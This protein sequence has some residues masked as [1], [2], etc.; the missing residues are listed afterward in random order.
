MAFKML[1]KLKMANLVKKR[2]GLPSAPA[3]PSGAASLMRKPSL[4]PQR[5]ASQSAP[6]NPPG[7]S[8]GNPADPSAQLAAAAAA[9]APLAEAAAAQAQAQAPAPES[10]ANAAGPTERG[11]ASRPS[12]PAPAA[13]ASAAPALPPP[14]PG[15]SS[16]VLPGGLNDAF[17]LIYRIIAI[18]ISLVIIVYFLTAAL[19]MFIYRRTEVQQKIRKTLNKNIMNKD[20]TDIA[21]IDYLKNNSEDE[22]YNVFAEQKMTSALYMLSGIGVIVLGLQVGTFFGLKLW[23]VVKRAEFTDKIEVPMK[24][25][26]VI[27]VG[28]A[29]A[30]LLNDTYKG[31]FIKKTQ[32]NIKTLR[33]QLVRL[34]NFIF[35]SLG[36][37]AKNRFLPALQSDDLETCITVLKDYAR[38]GNVNDTQMTAE[39]FM[40]L[41][42][43]FTVNVYSFYRYMI[44][45]GD[46]AFDDIRALFT[47]QGIRNRSVEPTAYLY[48]NQPAFVPNIYPTIRASLQPLLGSRERAFVLE[49]GKMMRELNRQLIA[50]QNISSGKS[51]LSGYLLTVFIIAGLWVAVLFGIFFQEIQP[52][53]G[54]AGQYLNAIWLKFK[55]I[56]LPGSPLGIGAMITS[57]SR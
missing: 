29:A 37:D 3:A 47:T 19:D 1:S 39:D 28:V 31:T 2:P 5:N 18:L 21:A 34:N 25:V 10:A 32:P 55:A 30:T 12:E 17:L 4:P 49:L 52:Y 6:G 8:Q 56:V 16:V 45:E 24:L 40:A 35:T 14:P 33:T 27:V 41:K 43:I 46:A 15:Q 36:N 51:A 13:A 53:L 7:K 26:A 42:L 22:P 38:R 9:A 57:V 50:V 44:P 48:Y 54:I 11:E 20:T 23:A